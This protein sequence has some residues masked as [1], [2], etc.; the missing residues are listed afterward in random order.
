MEHEHLAP[1]SHSRPREHNAE[2]VFGDNG[3]S[4]HTCIKGKHHALSGIA[5]IDI[6][7]RRS[8]RFLPLQFL[9]IKDV[10]AGK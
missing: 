8:C 4:V 7:H 6:R 5:R 2:K 10:L 3:Q 1:P 9:V